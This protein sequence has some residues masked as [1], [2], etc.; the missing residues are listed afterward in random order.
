MAWTEGR[1]SDVPPCDFSDWT[2]LAEVLKVEGKAPKL[3]LQLWVSINRRE[4]RRSAPFLGPKDSRLTPEH[5]NGRR[6]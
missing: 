3:D 5:T 1:L 4:S 6:Q 2:A